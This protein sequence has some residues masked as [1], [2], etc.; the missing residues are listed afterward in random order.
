MKPI[1][2]LLVVAAGLSLTGCLENSG[3]GGSG[4]QTFADWLAMQPPVVQNFFHRLPPQAQYYYSHRGPDGWNELARR[5]RHDQWVDKQVDKAIDGA[6][7]AIEEA[8]RGP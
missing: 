1:L 8:D 6:R 2:A 5:A 7:H 3:P 4:G